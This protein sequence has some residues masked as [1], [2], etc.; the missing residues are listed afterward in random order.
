MQETKQLCWDVLTYQ[1]IRKQKIGAS[2][3]FYM[4]RNDLLL[5]YGWGDVIWVKT[6]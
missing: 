5:G 6:N 1:A 3:F 2:D 4:R